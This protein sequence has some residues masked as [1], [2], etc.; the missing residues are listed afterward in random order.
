MV[1]ISLIKDHIITVEGLNYYDEHGFPLKVQSSILTLATAHQLLQAQ[2]DNLDGSTAGV[3]LPINP[4]PEPILPG[5]IWIE[6]E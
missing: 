2:V 1:A 3:I 6:T 4:D 5:S